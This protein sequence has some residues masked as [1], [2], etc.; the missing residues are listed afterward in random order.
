MSEILFELKLKRLK[1][2]IE[3]CKKLKKF[4]K[5]YADY[6]PKLREKKKRKVSNIVLAVSIL[7]VLIYTIASFWLMYKTGVSVDSTLTTCFY[8]FFTGEIF[9]LA[10]IK[11]G[12][13]IKG[14][15]KNDGEN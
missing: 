1:K 9:V 14:E 15:N 12:K 13:T 4:E 2:K 5:D 6:I 11:L 8:A 7:A 10:G 3:R